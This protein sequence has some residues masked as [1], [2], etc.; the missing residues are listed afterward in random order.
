VEN[1]KD[2]YIDPGAARRDYLK[3]M[4]NHREAVRRMCEKLGIAYE[5]FDTER[6][7]ELA[8]FDFMRARMEWGK[9]ARRAR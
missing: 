5:M 4:A 3:K 2:L 6:P 8:L 7:L 1:Q 9:G